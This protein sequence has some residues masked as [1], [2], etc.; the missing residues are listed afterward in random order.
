MSRAG[1]FLHF[2]ADAPDQPSAE[3][4][5]SWGIPVWYRWGVRESLAS[6]IPNSGFAFPIPL[7]EQ[8]QE[9]TT[10]ISVVPSLDFHDN[11]LLDKSNAIHLFPG[12]QFPKFD[13]SGHCWPYRFKPHGFV[14]IPA[15][16]SE[17][18][19][20]PGPVCV[21]SQDPAWPDLIRKTL[22][23]IEDR[24]SVL[25]GF[26]TGQRHY[27]NYSG[28]WVSIKDLQ[29]IASEILNT[30][31]GFFLAT[32]AS[33]DLQNFEYDMDSQLGI[34]ERVQFDIISVLTLHFGF[35]SSVSYQRLGTEMMEG[36]WTIEEKAQALINM[37]GLTWIEP[38]SLFF[39]TELG[40]QCLRF[41]GPFTSKEYCGK[42]AA[43]LWD[44]AGY[45]WKI[46]INHNP[47]A[48]F[49][50]L[51]DSD[52]GRLYMF[53]LPR[54]LT[55][56][57]W[58]VAIPSPASAL[59]ICR[60]EGDLTDLD[61]AK[62]LVESGI[63]FRTL[64]PKANMKQS[65]AL[66]RNGAPISPPMREQGHTFSAYDLDY[67]ERELQAIMKLAQTRAALLRGGFVWQIALKFLSIGDALRGPSGLYSNSKYM[68]KAVD[69]FGA[70]YF[71]DDLNF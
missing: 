62:E 3:W 51:V 17:N 38:D 10:W 6:S 34:A 41:S 32:P 27:D 71:D 42:P 52:S 26:D 12:F 64:Q 7:A 59:F 69:A 70:E 9:V 43:D 55:L 13:N 50:Q 57:I 2:P 61:I 22:T 65:Q 19:V 29:G 45:D 35:D 5:M 54:H 37:L 11:I 24:W 53:D 8:I 48:S 20:N 67:Y 58:K 46:F 16:L 60:L 21:L 47:R 68:F 39:R 23:D 15:L 4:F 33:S 14:S 40:Q 31:T 1:I 30:S 66:E 56:A 25:T 49:L 36:T 28:E 63:P 44:L 18:S